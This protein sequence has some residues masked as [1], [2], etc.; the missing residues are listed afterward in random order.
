LSDRL[1]R[2]HSG[3]IRAPATGRWAQ[4]RAGCNHVRGR[5]SGVGWHL[6]LL[7]HGG[8]F[9]RLRTQSP[10]GVNSVPEGKPCFQCE[11]Q[12]PDVNDGALLTPLRRTTFDPPSGRVG[13]GVLSVGTLPRSR[14]LSR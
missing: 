2:P 14:S 1:Y 9:G 13:H 4:S 7:A 6:G 5:P 12:L 8:F 10:H 11:M 3:P